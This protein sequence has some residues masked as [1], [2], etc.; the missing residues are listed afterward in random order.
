MT[1]SGYM[2]PVSSNSTRRRSVSLQPNRCATPG[3]YQ[4][5]SMAA[6][7]TS[8]APLGSR[9]PAVGAQPALLHGLDDLRQDHVRLG[10]RDGGADVVTGGQLG[11]ER[12]GHHGPPRVQADDLAAARSTAGTGR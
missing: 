9:M 12:V 2:P 1:S 3:R 6:L 10:D 5:G 8:A 4:T 7:V 11:G